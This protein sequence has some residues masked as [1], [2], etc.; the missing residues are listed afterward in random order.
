MSD[1][2]IRVDGTT[3]RDVSQEVSNGSACQKKKFTGDP[4]QLLSD[5]AT[6]NPEPGCLQVSARGVSWHLYLEDR[7][8]R[9]ATHSVLSLSELTYYLRYSGFEA[10]SQVM[11]TDSQF[12]LEFAMEEGERVKL[13]EENT[14]IAQAL[15]WLEQR[16]HLNFQQ[17]ARISDR[18]SR[19]ALEPYLWL[20]TAEYCWL[21]GA[22]ATVTCEPMLNVADLLL[23]Y[24]QRLQAWQQLGEKILSPHQRPYFFGNQGPEEPP[25]PLL[26]K[27]AKLLRGLSISQLAPILKQDSLKVAQL[28]YPYIQSGE[29][30]LREPNS[31]QNRLPIVPL[32]SQPIQPPASQPATPPVAKAPSQTRAFKIACIDDSPTILKEMQSFL[33]GDEYEITTIDDPIKAP[34]LLFRLRPDLILMDITMPEINGYKLCGLLRSSTV[35]FN[36]PIIMVTGRTGLIDKARAKVV[37]ATDYLAKPFTRSSLLS[38]VEQ[39][40]KR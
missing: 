36:T 28:L 7:C 14:A 12:R 5:I 4:F 1:L 19:E 31:P 33:N 2:E 20:A 35:L 10:A 9:Y 23:E 30:V 24:R 17:I 3:D 22:T 34:A 40:L 39:H 11:R 18:L 38:V 15:C 32:S 29:L 16:G 37:G 27:L 26:T 25:P 21:S 8:L 13:C 6:N